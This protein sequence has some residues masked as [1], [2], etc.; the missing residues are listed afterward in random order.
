MISRLS[1]GA[2]VIC[3]DGPGGKL[4]AVIVDRATRNITHIAVV[5]ESVLHGEERLVP[6]D[7]VIKT[8]RDAVQLSCTKDEILH[9]EPFT[10]T[11]FL[12]ME[13]GEEGYAYALPYMTTYP[14]MMMTPELGYITVQDRIVPEGQVAIHR[15]MFVEAV[16]GMV[17]E[18][19]ELLIDPQSGQI[20][21]FLLMKGHG[22]GQKEVAIQVSDIDHVEEETLYLKISKEKIGQLPSLPVKRAWDEVLAI[23]T[24]QTRLWTKSRNYPSSMPWKL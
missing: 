15:G 14:D 19:G 9:M 2:K 10:R 12:E 17:G 20:T 1:I 18:V 22:W 11:H 7:R 4:T 16:D 5:E 6:I 8:T 13:N 3:T 23:K 24:W 21:H